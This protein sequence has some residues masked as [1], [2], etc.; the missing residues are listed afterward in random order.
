MTI[1][2]DDAIDEDEV[3][4]CCVKSVERERKR[5][6]E[7]GGVGGEGRKRECKEGSRMKQ[8]SSFGDFSKYHNNGH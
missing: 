4:V 7:R 6:R 1:V 5:K 8:S 3:T 2:E